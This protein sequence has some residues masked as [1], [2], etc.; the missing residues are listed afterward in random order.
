MNPDLLFDGITVVVS[1]ALSLVL[2]VL[3]IRGLRRL[4][5][6][7][8]IQE[9]LSSQHQSKAG[10]PTG[11]GML[12]VA[13]ALLGGLLS[14]RMHSGA[15][16]ALAALGLFGLLGLLDDLTKLRVGQVG[17]PARLKFPLQILFAI[18]VAWLAQ[19]PQHLLPA[20][21]SWI[22]WPLAI[23]VIVG[24]ANG[25]NFNDGIDGLAGGTSVIALVGVALV[26]PGA[27]AGARAVA[28]TLVGSLFAFLWFNRF[29]ARI[30][31]GD[32]GSLGLGAALAAIA[33]QEGWAILLPLL[34]LVFVVE[35]LSVM[36][37][38]T[39]FKATGGH[40]V[41]KMTPLHLTFQLEGWSEN[42]IALTFWGVA[43]AALL[44]SGWIAH[45]LT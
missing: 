11:G 7:Q 9:E 40:R 26:L 36:I 24:A 42:R 23:L 2:Y 19:S 28:M 4:R 14:L 37:Q 15:G 21:V 34:G 16:P 30:F 18:P 33:L 27:P 12:F 5:F 8:V 31:M 29:P 10:T 22:Y 25:V 20:E 1:C 38:V 39:V 3:L 17:I 41:F 6:G 35:T 44:A 32:T 13:L 45:A 43:I